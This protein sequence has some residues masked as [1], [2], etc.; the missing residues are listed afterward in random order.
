MGYKH[1]VEGNKIIQFDDYE[2][3]PIAVC[4]KAKEA[5]QILE[6]AWF[7][8]D[9]KRKYSAAARLIAEAE[10]LPGFTWIN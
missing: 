6:K 10:S 1:K 3:S 9:V 4:D 5:L 8:N 2:S 7:L